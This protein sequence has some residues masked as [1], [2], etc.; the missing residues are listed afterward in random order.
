MRKKI[1]ILK[2]SFSISL[3]IV[4]SASYIF[5][6]EPRWMIIGQ[7]WKGHYR[8]TV[9]AQVQPAERAGQTGHLA[10]DV[11]VRGATQG[12]LHPAPQPRLAAAPVAAPAA[13]PLR[14]PAGLPRRR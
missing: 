3:I 11:V 13:G 2:L 9:G 14:V 12:A 4:K 1:R 6:L 5:F 7:Y 8:E 10:V